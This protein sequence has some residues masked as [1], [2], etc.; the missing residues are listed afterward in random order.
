MNKVK[1][2]K[3]KMLLISCGSGG[4]KNDQRRADSTL[5]AEGGAQF[6]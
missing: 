1:F 4:L 3:V 5:R 6:K 2:Q